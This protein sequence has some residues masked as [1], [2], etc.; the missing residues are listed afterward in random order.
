MLMH[1][2]SLMSLHRNL[3]QVIKHV[4]TSSTHAK[5]RALYAVTVDILFI[6]ESCIE[7]SRPIDLPAIVFVDNKPM[8]HVICASTPRPKQSKHFLMLVD[9]IR[10]QVTLG[11][12]T[13][14]KIS[15]HDNLA[16]LLTKIVT[17]NAFQS[18]ANLLLGHY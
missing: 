12:L 16:D 10:D 7:L 1:T 15:S 2:F 11:Y 6:I 8:L 9:W 13:L 17:R 18:K 5:M 4:V 3:K 14:E